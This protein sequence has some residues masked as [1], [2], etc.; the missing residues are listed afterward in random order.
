MGPSASSTTI[1]SYRCGL[2]GEKYCTDRGKLTASG[3]TCLRDRDCCSDKYKVAFDAANC[4]P[5]PCVFKC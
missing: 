2:Y 4:F 1:V 3:L 5:C